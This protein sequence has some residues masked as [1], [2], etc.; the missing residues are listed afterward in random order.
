MWNGGEKAFSLVAA[1][2]HFKLDRFIPEEKHQW[3]ELAI[4]GGPYSKEERK[5]F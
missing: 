1:L 3:R 5:G 2:R 4:R